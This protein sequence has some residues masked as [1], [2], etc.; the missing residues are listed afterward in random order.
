MIT[1]DCTRF[2][3]ANSKHESSM[4]LETLEKWY[5]I[6]QDEERKKL[7]EEAGSQMKMRGIEVGEDNPNAQYKPIQM[8]LHFQV[9]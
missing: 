5:E 7:G 8:G 2:L 6:K 9:D 1:I 3:L 4:F